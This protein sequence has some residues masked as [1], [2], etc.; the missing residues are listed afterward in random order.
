M[1]F[2]RIKFVLNFVQIDIIQIVVYKFIYI[3]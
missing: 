1:E 2:L 3:N